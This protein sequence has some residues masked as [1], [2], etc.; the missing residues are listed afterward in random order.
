[1]GELFGGQ[2]LNFTAFTDPCAQTANAG[3]ATIK[4]L[5]LAQGVPAAAYATT[6]VQPATLVGNVSGGN[7]ALQAEQSETLTLGTV[8]TPEAIPGLAVSIDW[9]SIDVNGAIGQLGGGLVN[10]SNLCF[11]ILQNASSIYCK[12]FNRDPN[13]GAISPPSYVQVN[14]ANTGAMKTQGLDFEGQYT[15]DL[16]FGWLTNDSSLHVSTDWTWTTEFTLTPVKELSNVKNECVGSFG[17]TCGSPVTSLKGTSRL[18]WTDGDLSLSLR[19]PLHRRRDGRYLCPAVPRGQLHPGA[20]HPDQPGHPRLPLFRP[21][22]QLQHQRKHSR[23]CGRQQYP[24]HRAA[25]AGFLG[26]WQRHLP[27]D[28]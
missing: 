12:A 21:V 5:C 14:N 27:G 9:F 22:G 16:G 13:T 18:T 6:G 20:E 8:I 26:Q 15:Y 11:N 3:N 24:Q 2:T 28:V 10:S 4:S 17:T 23:G 7:P 19:Q 25:R 1:M